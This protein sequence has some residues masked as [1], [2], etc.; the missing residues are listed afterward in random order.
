MTG[1]G[2]C[3]PVDRRIYLGEADQDK[4][5]RPTRVIGNVCRGVARLMHAARLSR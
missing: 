2:T 5:P 3:H 1:S 4:L